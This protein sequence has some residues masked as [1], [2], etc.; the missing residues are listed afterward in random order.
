[1]ATLLAGVARATINPPHRSRLIGYGDRFLPSR[2][3]HD[4]LTATALALDDGETRLVLI[5]LDMLCLN[6]HVVRGIRR[7]IEGSGVTARDRVMIS[8]SH[9]HAG[10]VAYSTELG[11]S[12]TRRALSTLTRKILLITSQAMMS[13][14]PVTLHQGR[15]QAFAAVNRR[16]RG[17]DGTVK[18][19][20]DRS[21]PVDPG[22]DVLQLRDE[23]GEPLAT[24]VD[25][26]CHPAV[27]GPRNR[28]VSAEWPGVMRRMVEEA[29]GG[30]CLFLQGATGDLNPDHEWGDDDFEAMDRIG[31]LVGSAALGV[32]K[33]GLVDREATPLGAARRRLWLPVVPTFDEKGTPLSYRDLASRMTRVP[34]FL[35]D[36]VLDSVYP[37]ET[38]TRER[39]GR[40]EVAL[41]IQALRIGECAILGHAA[42]T[43][44][45]IGLAI[46][47]G[48][49]FAHTLFAGYTNGC[50]GYLPTAEA[51]AEGGY[52]VE[53][54]P[55]AYRISGRFDPSSGNR[56]IER[57]LSL[58]EKLALPAF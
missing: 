17:P 27:L 14:R 34:R 52:E 58:L 38:V 15:A 40:T 46:K 42:E 18:I 39:K 1:M 20:V 50:I 44:S 49:P 6:E 54:A 31:R 30:H 24:L 26:A 36:R 28:L 8:C 29:I 5:A 3:V 19:G 22:V 11:P 43:F 33:G 25:F 55:L 7:L 45:E 16:E 56:A 9:T 48:S 32:C 10:P 13:C 37:W 21:R 12:R 53:H 51:H 4:D 2:G 57:S 47:K 35:V 23:S 41:E